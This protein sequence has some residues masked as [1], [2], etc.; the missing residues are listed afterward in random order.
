MLLRLSTLATGRTGVRRETAELLAGLLNA[1]H[2]AGRAR[3]RLARLLRRPRPARA[4]RARAD[5]RGRRARRVRRRCCRP[6]RRSPRPGSTPVELAAKEGLALINGTDG[7]LGML[8]LAIADLRLLLRTA[9]IAAAMSRRGPARHR[10]GLRRRPAGAPAAPGPGALGRQPGRAA[11]RL[12]RGGLPPRARTATGSRT[13]T[14]CAARRRCTAPPATPSSTPPRSPGA[15][16]PPPSTTRWCSPRT[17][18]RVQRQ[19]PRR[20]GRATCSTS[21]RS[22]RPTWPRSASGVPT[23]SSTRRATTGCRRSSPT[24]PASTAAT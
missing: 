17:A 23:G 5:G 18:G 20:A 1:R 3:V 15:S 22:S 24:T 9:D 4:L 16:W 8:V 6:P 14:R 2:H 12:R 19:L 7:M 21:W 11:R 10:P 13:P